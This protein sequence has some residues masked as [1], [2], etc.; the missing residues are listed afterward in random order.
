MSA[1][2]FIA[3]CGA[4]GGKLEAGHVDKAALME[5]DGDAMKKRAPDTFRVRFATSKGTFAVAVERALSPHGADRF[6]NLVRSGYYNGNKFFRVVPGFV[7]QWG[8][9]GDPELNRTWANA[10]IPDD[11]VQTS[12]A[13]GT[14]TYAKPGMPN[15]RSTQVFINF[16]DNAFLDPQGFAPFGRVVEGMDVVESLNGEYGDGPS[17]QQQQIGNQGNAFLE[18]KYPNLD[19]IT[20]ATVE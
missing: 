18:E 8:M 15:S 5:P 13:R 9:S 2:A 7:V 12:N 19:H 4:G 1:C 17:R 11:P 20:S 3:A 14:I 10:T 6:Y 16:K